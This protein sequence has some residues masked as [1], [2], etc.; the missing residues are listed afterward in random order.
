MNNEL[1]YLKIVHYKT[2][3][4]F[5]RIELSEIPSPSTGLEQIILNRRTIREPSKRNA[6]LELLHP[7]IAKATGRTEG[8]F[9]AY[10]SAGARYPLE[11]YL[12]S[13]T[14]QGLNVGAYHYSPKDNTLEYLWPGNYRDIVMENLGGK[15]NRFLEDMKLFFVISSIE[16]RT[17]FKY[18]EEGRE[19]SLIEAGYL[20][21]NL[22]YL[23]QEKGF[24]PVIIGTQWGRKALEKVFDLN[25]AKEHIISAIAVL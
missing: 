3:P 10:P 20:G 17:T 11:L 7:L 23:L 19:F 13:F 22:I 6:T 5:E 24:H 2:Y 21:A 14:V 1:N 18:G 8:D 9:R 16:A 12:L 15:E 25:S 4:R